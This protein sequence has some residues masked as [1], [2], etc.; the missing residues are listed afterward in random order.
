MEIVSGQ[1]LQLSGHE[2]VIELTH[3]KGGAFSGD[4]DTSAFLLTKSEKVRG[5]SDFIFYNQP[6]SPDGAVIFAKTAAGGTFTVNTTKLDPAI[7][8][9]AFTLAID[10]SSTIAHLAVLRLSIPGQVT[11]QVPLTDRSEKA[12]IVG[13]LYRHNGAWKLKGLGQGFN[14]GLAP[15]ATNFGVVVD[16]EEPV[17]APAPAPAPT[18]IPIPTKPPLGVSLEKILAAQAPYLVNLAKPVRVSLEKHRLE[19]VKAKVAFVLDA[20]GSMTQQ[21]KSGNVQAVLERIAVL[22]VQFDDDGQM[23]VWGFAERHKKYVDVS[24]G[25][26]KGYI[27]RIQSEGKR[28]IFELLPSLGGTNNEPP[29]ITELIDTF[30][31]SKEPVFVVFI[32]DGGINKTKLIKEALRESANYPI[33]WKFVGL[34]G[35]NY[36]ILENLDDF[37]DRLLDNTDFFPIDNFKSVPD[38]VLYDKLLT[39]FSSWL[40]AAKDKGIL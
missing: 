24:L 8:K 30:K 28:G 10:G 20:S 14:G 25:N 27:S 39:E 32:T 5:D 21:F 35:S 37:T 33:F 15:L 29:V 9:I 22:S 11:Y 26:L 16:D 3:Q 34:G 40:K 6:E 7:E 17:S 4:A 23:D 19:N 1:N 38:E 13:H 18:P 12:V 2:F 31:N 36:G